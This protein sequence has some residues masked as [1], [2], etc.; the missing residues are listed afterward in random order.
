MK[1]ISFFLMVSF[2]AFSCNESKKE[3]PKNADLL[4]DNLAGKVEQTTET[5][6][7]T[8]STGKV[9]EQDSCCVVT[10]RYDEKGYGIS[11]ASDNKA[12]TEKYVTEYTHYDNGAMK[13]I[14]TTKNG[15]PFSSVSIQ[16]DSAGKYTGAQSYDS[17]NKMDFYYTDLITNDYGQLTGLKEMKPDSTLKMTMASDY[18]KQYFKGTTQK[19]SSGKEIFSS[20]ITLDDK[21]NMI[22]RSTKSVT[23]DS[24]INKT[25]KYRYDSYDD[26]S[27]WTQRTQTDENGKPVK[28]IKRTITYYKE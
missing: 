27:N 28:I 12:G 4:A 5:T 19:D 17:T 22:E 25:V 6:F 3:L 16:I 15:S 20:K 8:D 26:T 18:D 24:T 14:K 11:S 2:F 23:K 7:K 21:N 9:G 10:T 1:R 13:N